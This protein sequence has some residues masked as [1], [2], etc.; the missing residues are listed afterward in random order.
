[1][2]LWKVAY[3]KQWGSDPDED[4]AEHEDDVNAWR[5]SWQGGYDAGEGWATALVDGVDEQNPAEDE[6][7]ED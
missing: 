7:E 3:Q 4:V 1:M 6:N 5:V 2:D